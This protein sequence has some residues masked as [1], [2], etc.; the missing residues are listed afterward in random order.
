MFTFLYLYFFHG[1]TCKHN[2]TEIWREYFFSVILL[3]CLQRHA[4]MAKGMPFCPIV[5]NCFSC[6]LFVLE[7]FGN[8]KLW[9]GFRRHLQGNTSWV[10]NQRKLEEFGELNWAVK[11][12]FFFFTYLSN[13]NEGLSTKFSPTNK[14]K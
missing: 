5:E 3:L 10:N 13:T 14:R 2:I 7:E 1:V 12:F 9:K 4:N 8:T 6:F 11:G